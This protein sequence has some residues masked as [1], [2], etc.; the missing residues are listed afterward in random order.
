MMRSG[1]GYAAAIDKFQE[2]AGYDSPYRHRGVRASLKGCGRRLAR[3]QR[4]AGALTA[5]TLTVIQLTPAFAAA[6]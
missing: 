3:P 4:Q 6:A 1:A 2:W 5:D